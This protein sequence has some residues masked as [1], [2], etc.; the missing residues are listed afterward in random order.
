MWNLTIAC[1]ESINEP[2]VKTECA[3]DSPPNMQ[4]I[5]NH[6]YTRY[7]IIYSSHMSIVIETHS[8]TCRIFASFFEAFPCLRKHVK[9]RSC[10]ENT[11]CESRRRR[12]RGKRDQTISQG[13]EAI[14]GSFFSQ[15]ESVCSSTHLRN[16]LER[17]A[18]F[19]LSLHY[20]YRL[21]TSDL[22]ESCYCYCYWFL[23]DTR[24]HCGHQCNP[25]LLIFSASWP[26]SWSKR[27]ILRTKSL[28][29]RE[30]QQKW[31]DR[32]PDWQ[33]FYTTSGGACLSDKRWD[34]DLSDDEADDE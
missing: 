6:T 11:T 23:P 1:R 26:T 13:N 34:E 27:D 29:G 24:G 5:R 32:Q 30:I 28:P 33:P 31:F 25:L 3:M 2:D 9:N 14:F 22:T 16:T 12:R 18:F 8:L 20:W 15:S 17:R 7:V 21:W 10:K 4:Y 19:D